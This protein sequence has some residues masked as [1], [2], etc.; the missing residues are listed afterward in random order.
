MIADIQTSMSLWLKVAVFGLAGL[1]IIGTIALAGVFVYVPYD[2]LVNGPIAAQTLKDL[3]KEFKLI[4]PLPS[5]IELRCNSMNKTHQG[6]VGCEYKASDNYETIR[7]HYDKELESHGWK[8]V[9]ERPV[10]IWSRDYGGK[11][12]FYCKGT[13]TATLQYAGK[14]PGIQYT[15]GFG[16]SWGLFDEC[17]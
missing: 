5:A 14:E 2:R 9:T 7:A 15:Y 12:A 13:Y 3:E 1:F 10:M 4:A 8:F 17:K 11:E 16:L 6:D